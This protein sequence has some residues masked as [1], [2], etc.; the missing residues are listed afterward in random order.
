M[1]TEV[2]FVHCAAHDSIH[3]CQEFEKVLLAD[4]LRC[5]GRKTCYTHDVVGV[6]QLHSA[7]C[8]A[9][10]CASLLACYLCMFGVDLHAC[11]LL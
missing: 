4:M 2:I 9:R 5:E 8:S 7:I 10:A 6:L 1:R 3:T 11:S